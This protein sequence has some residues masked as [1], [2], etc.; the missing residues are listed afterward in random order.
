MKQKCKKLEKD[1]IKLTREKL[2]FQRRSE[3][4]KVKIN[5]MEFGMKSLSDKFP[6]FNLKT[7]LDQEFA[8]SKNMI[9]AQQTNENKELDALRE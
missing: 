7:K 2:K 4:L 3:N 5:S 8:L 9:K 6:D 1:Y